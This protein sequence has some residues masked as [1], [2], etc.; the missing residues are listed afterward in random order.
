MSTPPRWADRSSNIIPIDSLSA[1]AKMRLQEA[2]MYAGEAE[3]E[4]EAATEHASKLTAIADAAI[5]QREYWSRI[6][7][8]GMQVD[9]RLAA[10][11]EVEVTIEPEAPA[12]P[13]PPDDPAVPPF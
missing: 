8:I 6:A 2:I 9:L 12:A 10:E 3:K 1:M 4:A 5:E 13:K 7:E 11:G